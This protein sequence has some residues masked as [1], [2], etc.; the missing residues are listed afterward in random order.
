MKINDIL[1]QDNLTNQPI[2]LV[3]DFNSNANKFMQYYIKNKNSYKHN[4]IL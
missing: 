1:K 2:I 4:K 3:M